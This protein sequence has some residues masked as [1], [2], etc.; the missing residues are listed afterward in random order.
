[1]VSGMKDAVWRKF[2]QQP[3]VSETLKR[4]DFILF[5][6]KDV[7][8]VAR[9]FEKGPDFRLLS[10]F[11]KREDLPDIFIE[12]NI[13]ILPIS[14]SE[15]ML[16]SFQEYSDFERGNPAQIDKFIS[17]NLLTLQGTSTEWNEN[18]WI[19]AGVA[20]GALNKAFGDDEELIRTLTG[21]MGAGSWSFKI[22]GKNG[23]YPIELKNPQIEIDSVLETNRAIYI[24]EAKRVKETNFLVRQ[25]YFP[26]RK[27]LSDMGIKDKPVIPVFYEI[28]SDSQY[29]RV[30]I[31]DFSDVNNYNSI[32]EVRRFEFQLIDANESITLDQLLQ[33]AKSVITR[34]TETHLFPQANNVDRYVALVNTLAKHPLNVQEISRLIDMDPRQGKYYP[35]IL[36]YFNLA[37]YNDDK[38]YEL[39]KLGKHINKQVPG[40]RNL[41]FAYEILRVELFNTLFLKHVAIPLSNAE[42]IS[43]MKKEQLALSEN[44]M[45]R[46]ASS[47][48][49]LLNWI[50][51]QMPN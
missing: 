50:M 46:R 36:V 33:F 51:L 5:T 48:R 22:N 28:N 41:M 1:M 23:A 6:S 9:S 30:R 40:Q 39:T 38:K 15:F 47:V 44:T 2:L 43:E 25:L 20:S 24:I 27:L 21:R 4:D 19:S 12:Q 49:N 3:Q 18:S 16:G 37:Q 35:D 26:Y 17:P 10:K 45:N 13:N 11:D 8:K 42:I 34:K 7:N 29:A 31:Y 32:K 14:R